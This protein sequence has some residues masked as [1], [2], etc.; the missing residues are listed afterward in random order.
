MLMLV[1]SGQD[2]GFLLRELFLRQLPREI[3]NHLAQTT[4]TY[5][6]TG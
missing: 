2:P 1:P 3:Q 4:N 6:L 5:G